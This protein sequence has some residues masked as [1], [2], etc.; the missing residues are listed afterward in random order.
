ML[1]L[2]AAFRSHPSASVRAGAGC[3]R[4][5]LRRRTSFEGVTSA[6]DDVSSTAV[7]LS[8]RGGGCTGGDSGGASRCASSSARIADANAIRSR[9]EA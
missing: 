2:G 7:E 6:G 5:T 3:T 9:T 4:A 8:C 1:A